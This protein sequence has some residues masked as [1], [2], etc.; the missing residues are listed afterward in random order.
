MTNAQSD[1]EHRG[2]AGVLSS[3]INHPGRV[4]IGLALLTAVLVFAGISSASDE[5]ASFSPGGEIFDTGELVERTFRPSTTSL[6]FLVVDEGA[7]ALDLATSDLSPAF[8]TYFDND[9]GRTVIGLFSI[10]DAVDEELRGT[11][12]ARGLEGATE[13][14]VQIAVSNVLAEGRPTAVLRDALSTQGTSE[15]GTVAGQRITVWSAPAFVAS[16]RLTTTPSRS[17]RFRSGWIS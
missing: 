1:H 14:D 4:V 13:N 10:A 6:D 16:V 15:E 17:R 11:G 5:D 7:N 3:L 2:L 12:V 8:S 9:L